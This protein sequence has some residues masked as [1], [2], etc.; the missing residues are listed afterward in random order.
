M[1]GVKILFSWRPFLRLQHR[2]HH[3]AQ[4]AHLVGD[5]TI[6]QLGSSRTS[7][8]SP[9]ETDT[10]PAHVDLVQRVSKRRSDAA[11]AQFPPAMWQT[12]VIDDPKTVKLVHARR[13]DRRVQRIFHH[14]NENGLSRSCW[15]T[16]SPMRSRTMGGAALPDGAVQL[17]RPASSGGPG[18]S[19]WRV[20][21][22]GRR[23]ASGADRRRVALLA[24]AGER[25]G[26]I[27]ARAHGQGRLRPRQ[28]VVSGSGCWDFPRQGAARV[29]LG[30]TLP[31]ATDADIKRELPEARRRRRAQIA[32]RGARLMWPAGSWTPSS[33][34][35]DGEARAE[36][37]PQDVEPADDRQTARCI[38]AN[39]TSLMN[40]TIRVS[41][42]AAVDGQVAPVMYDASGPATNATAPRPRQMP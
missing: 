35:P 6:N 34:R 25:G 41:V 28:G 32:Q 20:Q 37:V 14:P 16:S 5:S 22:T 21:M 3:R 19:A 31:A 12:T 13:Q 10:N 17:G 26:H 42:G 9:G 15:P 36:G 24:A 23:S 40:G 39:S 4:A 1:W 8:S 27:R 2:A 29:P 11:E 38:S 30:T 7:K 18:R 33:S